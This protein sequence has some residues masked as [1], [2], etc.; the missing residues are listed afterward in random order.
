MPKSTLSPKIVETLETGYDNSIFMLDIT[1][2]ILIL[3][4]EL[5]DV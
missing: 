3:W 2:G 5:L 1:G 4:E